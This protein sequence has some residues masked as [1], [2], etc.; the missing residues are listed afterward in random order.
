V[1]PSCFSE[2]K[3]HRD[4]GK[5]KYLPR[6]SIA[7]AGKCLTLIKQP[8]PL[9]CSS[10]S[11]DEESAQGMARASAPANRQSCTE[12]NYFGKDFG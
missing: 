8:L 7:K 2:N 11:S 5:E 3:R 1:V 4:G 10:G 9:C 12:E 6:R